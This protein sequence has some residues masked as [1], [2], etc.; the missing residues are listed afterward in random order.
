MKRYLF[1]FKPTP[2]STV[3]LTYNADLSKSDYYVQLERSNYPCIIYAKFDKD[4]DEIKEL[5]P[6]YLNSMR[7]SIDLISK[8]ISYNC[9]YNYNHYAYMSWDL[10]ND[11]I[12]IYLPKGSGYIEKY[13]ED[14]LDA[15]YYTVALDKVDECDAL[16]DEIKN[17]VKES[18]ADVF[19]YVTKNEELKRFCLIYNF[20]NEKYLDKRQNIKP[21]QDEWLDF[22]KQ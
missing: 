13:K 6:I 21:L 18:G 19:M 4:T 1:G 2:L 5:Y 14:K 22:Q 10:K 11:P 7:N 20:A 15:K 8:N 3:E 12:E 9:H 17:F 16:T